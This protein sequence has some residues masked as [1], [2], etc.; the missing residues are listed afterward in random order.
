MSK[1]QKR[2]NIGTRSDAQTGFSK[3]EWFGKSRRD[4]TNKRRGKKRDNKVQNRQFINVKVPGKQV[5][6]ATNGVIT[7]GL[8]L[9]KVTIEPIQGENSTNKPNNV[10]NKEK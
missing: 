5:E 3:S 6:V 8:G 1:K 4:R 10:D 7:D 9:I 2:K